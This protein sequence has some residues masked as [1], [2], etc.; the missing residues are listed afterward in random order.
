MAGHVIDSLVVELGLDPSKLSSQQQQTISNFK[1]FTSEIQS[2]GTKTEDA[3]EKVSDAIGGIRMQALEMFAVFSGGKGIITFASEITHANAS[4]GRLERNIGVSASTISAW[5]GAARLFG[6]DAQAMAQSFTA[7]SDAFAGWKI[8]ITSPL[9]A[10]L[11]AIS[12]AGG[13]IIDVNKGVEQSFLDL[14]T[15]LKAI[16]DRD[17]AQ[18]GVLGRRLGL[19][20]ALFDL[21]IKGPEGLKQVLDYVNKIGVATRGDTDAF[22]E[23]E[24]RINQMGLKAE[25][26]GRAA[27]GDGKDGSRGLASII[28]A[29]ADELNKPVS[30]A[31][32]WDA[33]TGSGQYDRSKNPTGGNLFG[34][35]P[36]SVGTSGGAFKSQAEK[37]TFIREQAL[38]RGIDPE[39]AMQVARTEGFNNFRSTVIRRDGSREPSYGAFQLYTGGGLGNDF[40]KATGL[41]PSDPANERD[42]IRFAL[43]HARRRGWEAFHGAANNHIPNWAGI[44]PAAPNTTSN[45]SPVS[46][47]T[48]NVYPPSGADV[49]GIVNDA[50]AQARKQ[51]STAAQANYGQN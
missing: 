46:I 39:V 48:L 14:S 40:Q 16:H 44:N 11:R 37:E 15:N 19:D 51:A 5:Q 45:S 12:T 33:L 25:S 4:L 29:L 34:A 2:T 13:K 3:L 18:A 9:I 30:E 6:G 1:K 28:I 32:P 26:L 10:D 17:P 49:K 38:A 41:D 43:D 42:T 47:E 50:Q 35:N 20:P 7:V 36:T 23:L 8:G 22:G 27:L 24:K 21:L 31:H